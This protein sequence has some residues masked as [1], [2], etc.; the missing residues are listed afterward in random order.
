[1]IDKDIAVNLYDLHD[2]ALVSYGA[3][4]DDM[5]GQ[6]HDLRWKLQRWTTPQGEDVKANALDQIVSIN[7]DTFEISGNVRPVT[8]EEARIACTVI[9]KLAY[10]S[11][12][13]DI[14]LG[15]LNGLGVAV[16]AGSVPNLVALS[17]QIVLDARDLCQKLRNQTA[18]QQRNDKA[19]VIRQRLDPKK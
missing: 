10:F 4:T 17:A 15:M 1:M 16:K 2:S 14:G 9:K 7:V 11:K 12:L 3:A 19:E 18:Q 13:N 6:L 8:D 5:A